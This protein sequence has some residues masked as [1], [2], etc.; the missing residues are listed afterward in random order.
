MCEVPGAFRDAFIALKGV[1]VYVFETVQKVSRDGR[2]MPR[3]VV[4]TQEQIFVTSLGGQIKRCLRIPEVAAVLH[5]DRQL[6]LHS[7]GPSSQDTW[8]VFESAPA[9]ATFLSCIQ[10]LS[11]STPNLI[12]CDAIDHATLQL[13]KPKGTSVHIEPL[14]IHLPALICQAK[15]KTSFFEGRTPGEKETRFENSIASPGSV[16]SGAS[17]FTAKPTQNSAVSGDTTPQTSPVIHG[18][19]VVSP[20]PRYPRVAENELPVWTNPTAVLSGQNH[21]RTPRATNLPPPMWTNSDQNTAW[22]KVGPLKRSESPNQ[23]YS[24]PIPTAGG[25]DR[26]VTVP[27]EAVHS[28]QGLAQ[29]MNG[30]VTAL[31]HHR[32]QHGASAGW[33]SNKTH[34][35]STPQRFHTTKR[36]PWEHTHNVTM[37]R[38]Q[39]HNNDTFA[40]PKASRDEQG[41]ESILYTMQ[42]R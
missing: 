21:R 1:R 23:S 34:L 3:V 12:P 16:L 2:M 29:E 28:V 8:L 25:G 32:A 40:T 39:H 17:N 13:A 6:V 30:G 26:M 19:E 11:P 20:G 37:D 31:R 35:S 4:V 22:P 10:A 33:P 42:T 18:R 5:C 27:G 7:A 9:A 15:R 38:T 24:V 41:Y 14:D 36:K